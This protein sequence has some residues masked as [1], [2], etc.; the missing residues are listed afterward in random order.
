MSWKMHNNCVHLCLCTFNKN[1]W[2]TV[3]GKMQ[4]QNIVFCKIKTQNIFCLCISSTMKYLNVRVLR[5][6]AP[7]IYHIMLAVHWGVFMQ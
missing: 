1:T 2:M 5:K 6:Y 3:S 7:K 4:I